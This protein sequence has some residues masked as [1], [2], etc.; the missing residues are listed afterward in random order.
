MIQNSPD[1]I[2][3]PGTGGFTPL[4][5]AASQG[6]LTVARFLLDNKANVNARNNNHETPLTLAALQGHK[7]MVELLL[8]R[9]ADVNAK[10]GVGYTALHQTALKGFNAVAETLITNRAEIDARNQLGA[11]PLQLAAAN[12][13]AALAESLLNHQAS[14]NAMNELGQTPLFSA[15]W[16]GHSGMMKV[17]L[18]AEAKVDA[19]DN[20]GRTALSYAAEQGHIN[21][22]QALLAVKADPNLGQIDLPLA[23]AV[24]AGH[25]EV[26]ETL[27]H[28][29][30]NPNLAGKF[31]R[32][33]RA[34]GSPGM[35]D[36][37][38]TFGP[39][40][41]LQIAV[42]DRNVS[43]V[44]LL[45]KYKADA[46]ATGT[47]DQPPKSLLFYVLAPKDSDLFKALLEAKANPNLVDAADYS[48]LM[49]ATSTPGLQYKEVVALLV[50][51][52]ADVNFAAHDGW[53]A[54]RLAVAYQNKEI[55]A[56]LLAKGANPNQRMKNDQT[57][58]EMAEGGAAN[59]NGSNPKL[60]EEIAVLLRQHGALDDLPNLNGIEVRRPQTGY[61]TTVFLKGTNDW[62]HFTLLDALFAKYFAA[63]FIANPG[64][65]A[66]NFVDRIAGGSNELPFPDLHRL[67]VVRQSAKAGQ[68]AK[69]IAVDLILPTGGV[70]C[71]KDMPL[72][73][74]DVVEIPE[75]EHTLQERPVGLTKEELQAIAR[76]REGNVGLIVRGKRTELKVWPIWQQASISH[77]LQRSEIR[78]ALFSSSDLSRVRVTRQ[79]GESTKPHEWIV[80][81]SG[82]DNPDIWLRDGDVI[83][84]PDKP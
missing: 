37:Y 67:I 80:D 45:L 74:G 68:P 71:T 52:G 21:S 1:L 20:N 48:P 43:M 39:Y 82:G 57:P 61:A 18:A 54:L 8:S 2:N 36:T 9:G 26:A 32:E 34:P 83:E 42:A 64:S 23:A 49:R 14:V 60:S 38:G 27:L 10:G 13:H 53:T 11:T 50:E 12:G 25:L 19:V 24:K 44:K 16:A 76:C 41:P 56:L 47:W 55:T 69:R 33:V 77:L 6:Q 15:A 75:R 79:A 70:D 40:L 62:N 29:G 84:V 58:L 7:A 78:G 31:S 63:T 65:A 5:T 28:S 17:L 72:E 35:P 3:A 59:P 46:N 51:A 30:A 81:C 4:H 66:A 22:V 73:F